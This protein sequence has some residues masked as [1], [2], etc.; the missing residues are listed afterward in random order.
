[1]LDN[2]GYEYRT[3]LQGEDEDRS[4]PCESGLADNFAT[5]NFNTKSGVTLSDII[6]IPFHDEGEERFIPV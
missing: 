5:F 3:N 6:V 1:V 4:F 2:N